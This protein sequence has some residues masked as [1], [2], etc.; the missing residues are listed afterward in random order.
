MSRR[1]GIA[2]AA[3]ATAVALAL[4]GC[5]GG[6][7]G[8]DTADTGGGAPPG[9]ADI[10]PAQGA[11]PEES[12][13]LAVGSLGE[14]PAVAP[15]ERGQTLSGFDEFGTP[16]DAFRQQVRDNDPASASGSEPDDGEGAPPPPSVS[17]DP[18]VSVPTDPLPVG[19]PGPSGTPTPDPG[20]PPVRSPRTLEADFDISGEPVV[21]R[22]GDAIP[23][24]TQQFAVQRVLVD[25]VVLKLVGGLLPDGTDSVT[26]EEGES[27]TLYNATARRSY[28]LK[29]VDIRAA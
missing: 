24:D 13:S 19:T 14:P 9:Q 4:A 22:E 10:P 28:K 16:Q 2:L 18:L 26:L 23:P 29:L 7:G 15:A 3:A 25:R 27:V 8:G 6:G 11:A 17:G 12:A 5:G 20:A 21:A 1:A